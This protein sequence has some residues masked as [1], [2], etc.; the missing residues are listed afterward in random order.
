MCRDERPHHRG[1]S[2]VLQHVDSHASRPQQIFLS[3][4]RLILTDDDVP[5]SVE[6]DGAAAHGTWR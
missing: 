3:S 2:I 4:K 6:Q 5:D 1:A